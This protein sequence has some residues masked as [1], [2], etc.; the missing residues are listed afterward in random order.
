MELK[1]KFICVKS[2]DFYD[3]AG[4]HISGENVFCF[5]ESSNNIVKAKI[6]NNIGDLHFGDVITVKCIPNGRYLKYEF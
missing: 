1:C 5:D 2:Y 4:N 6:T 3:E